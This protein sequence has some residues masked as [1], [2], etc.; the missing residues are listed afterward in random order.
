ME[1]LA[2]AALVV[3][4]AGLAVLLLAPA[5]YRAVRTDGRPT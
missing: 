5:A 3:G 2:P 1:G 4:A